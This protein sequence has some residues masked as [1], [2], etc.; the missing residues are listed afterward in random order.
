MTIYDLPRIVSEALPNAI[1]P[2]NIQAGFRVS[3]VWPFNRHIF[4][5]HE[6]LPAQVTDRPEPSTPTNQVISGRSIVENLKLR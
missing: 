1:T 5:E 2:S 4:G 6:F 3:G